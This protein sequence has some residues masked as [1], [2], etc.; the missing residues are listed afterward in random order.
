M[1]DVQHRIETL[2]AAEAEAKR[3]LEDWSARW[4]LALPAAAM[5][6]ATGIEQAEAALGVW[7]KVPGT[8]RERNNRARRVA[9][10]LRNIE[11]FECQAK[12]L[13]DDIAPDLAAL[14]ADAA[15]KILN[16]RLIA[17]RAAET[18][19]TESQRRLAKIIRAR[20]AADVAFANAE[21]SLQAV[22]K[23]SRR[24]KTSRMCSLA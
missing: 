21:S 5:P 13:L 2:V 20:E 15:V 7:S 16:D 4:S 17:A 19:R 23:N 1:S 11:A 22:A 24:T 8:I 10:M 3:S 9:G 18:R 6:V 12:D 14:P